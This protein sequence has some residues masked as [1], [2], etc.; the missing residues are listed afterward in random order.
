MSDNFRMPM[1]TPVRDQNAKAG[2][3]IRA[4]SDYS[5][6]GLDCFN[7]CIDPSGESKV[8]TLL[9]ME[10]RCMDGCISVNL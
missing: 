9:G 4:A 10:K 5:Q 3:Y 1:Y 7:M 6:L 2:S 8:D